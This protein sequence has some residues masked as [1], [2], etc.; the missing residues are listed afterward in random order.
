MKSEARRGKPEPSTATKSESSENPMFAVF[1]LIGAIERRAQRIV[2]TTLTEAGLTPDQYLAL[3]SLREK[4]GRPLREIADALRC[5]PSTVTGIVDTM[6][7][8]GLV[9]REANPEDRRSHLVRLTGKGRALRESTPDLEDFYEGCAMGMSRRE[10]EELRGMLLR[11]DGCL[12]AAAEPA[13]V[14]SSRGVIK[15]VQR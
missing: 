11:L 5:S 12:K 9:A 3:A 7:K 10:F 13:E 1:D 6:E 2:A 8:K 15:E 4:D 14:P